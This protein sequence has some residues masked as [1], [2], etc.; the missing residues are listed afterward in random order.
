MYFI[1]SNVFDSALKF[2]SNSRNLKEHRMDSNVI[3]SF[4]CVPA[5]SRYHFNLGIFYIRLHVKFICINSFFYSHMVNDLNASVSEWVSVY[6]QH[7]KRKVHHVFRNK[8]RGMF[9]KYMMWLPFWYWFGLVCSN[10]AEMCAMHDDNMGI[11]N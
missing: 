3:V 11:S 6:N 9:W 5:S 4:Y 8:K 7:Q 1:F 2:T 10:G